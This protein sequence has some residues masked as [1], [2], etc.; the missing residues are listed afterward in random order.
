L[1]GLAQNRQAWR[2]TVRLGA[3]PSFA[4]F[5]GCPLFESTQ[6]FRFASPWATLCR[7][8]RGLR[9]KH[10]EIHRRTRYAANRH[11]HWLGAQRSAA[12]NYKIDLRRSGQARWN[13]R[14]TRQ[15][16]ARLRSSSTREASVAGADSRA[17]RKP[18]RR[19]RVLLLALLLRHGLR[20]RQRHRTP[21]H[22]ESRG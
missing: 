1:S 21:S 13:F 11:R 20:R 3:E 12:R 9:C 5:A 17:S 10:C 16:P 6:G 2:R 18:C 19:R 15:W 7:P 4:R 14:K 22:A 8:L